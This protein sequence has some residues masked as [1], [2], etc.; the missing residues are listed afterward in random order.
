MRGEIVGRD[1]E[2]ETV[3]RFVA[4][5]ALGPGV[6]LIEGEPGIGK[7][8]LW[9]EAVHRSAGGGRRTLQARPTEAEST[10]SFTAL[11]DLLE[12]AL[13]EVA[14][15]VPDPQRKALEVALLHEDA[16]GGA[17]DLRAVALGA[18]AVLRSAAANGPLLIAVDDAQWMDA[19]SA[20]VLDF[21]IRRLDREPVRALIAARAGH[22]ERAGVRLRQGRPEDERVEINVGPLSADA[23][24]DLFRRRLGQSF[25]RPT[26][27]Q[28]H[29]TAAGN[30]FYALEL[31]RALI[32][33]EA[34]VVAYAPFPVPR[35]L[36]GLIDAR[37]GHLPVEVRDVLLVAA[38]LSRPTVSQVEAAADGRELDALLAVAVDAGTIELDDERLRFA[39]PL[40][41]SAIYASASAAKRRGLHGRLAQIVSEPEE[42][43][44]HLA[45][46]ANGP[47]GEIAS[48]LD[49]AARIAYGRAAPEAA[50]ALAEQA[51]RLTPPDATSDLVRRGIAVGDYQL[52]SGDTVRAREILEA[53]IEIAAPGPM[54]GRALHR[55][56]FVRVREQGWPA[57]ASTLERALADVDEEP[58]LKATILG[59]LSLY[60]TQTSEQ[61][62]AEAP[63]TAAVAIAERLGDPLAVERANA[64]LAWAE[65]LVGRVDQG[66]I[67]ARAR[68]GTDEGHGDPSTD[69][70]SWFPPAM[71]WA[72]LL[73]WSDQFDE[74]RVRLERMNRNAVEL[75]EESPL[76]PIL[77]QLGELECWAGNRAASERYA[78]EAREAGVQHGEPV[79]APLWLYLDGLLAAH[80]GRVDEARAV[81]SEAIAIAERTGN[82]RHLV[83]SIAL[84]GFIDLSVGDAAAARDWL[85]RATDMAEAAS[86]GEPG[87]LRIDGDAIEALM[88][89]G[90]L[91]NAERLLERLEE[92]GQRLNRS[93]ALAIAGRCRG[94]L[95]SARG[96]AAGAASAFERS[97]EHHERLAQ[98]FELARTLLAFGAAQRRANQKRRA[99]QTLAEALTM[100]DRLEMPLWAAKARSELGRIS[101]RTVAGDALTPSERQVAALAARG[102][103]NREIAEL[104]FMSVKTVEAHLS[105]T[106]SKLGVRSRTELAG[107]GSELR[108]S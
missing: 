64:T 105:R 80:A 19:S 24:D 11:G 71:D 1:A 5:D 54:R 65:F 2:L 35:T 89:T 104:S 4:R 108:E 84:L 27:R 60:L 18:L 97:L 77:F 55:L 46:A 85:V 36:T 95:S 9:Q 42:R 15:T 106:Y 88:L 48:V 30:P 7:T 43:A 73:K 23:L 61:P 98:P 10:L 33:T 47:D 66:D 58:R 83:R 51:L 101:G 72:L 3:D 8:T 6:L 14:A 70:P 22:D 96:D 37:L 90:D 50:A 16:S 45:L 103:T 75:H 81:A 31:A 34:P 21:A 94:M 63:A 82:H 59:D 20:R 99:R 67:L 93:W 25:L 49:A 78:R 38:A 91:D 41:A 74:A 26:L 28:L 29:A 53:T 87:V 86:Y 39:H 17:P 44:R 92:R 52:K 57:G 76:P 107:M 56:A 79:L 13:A 32:N 62:R 40:L 102:K 100:F 69:D 68:A 12:P